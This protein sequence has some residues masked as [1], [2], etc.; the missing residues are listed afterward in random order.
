V[1]ASGGQKKHNFGQI[2]TFG[3]SCTDTVLLMMAKFGLLEETH[4]IHLRAKFRLDRL[5]LSIDV[6]NVFMF[7][8]FL[9][10]FLRFLTFF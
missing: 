10:R 1:S 6:K 3:D 8:L 2:L 5:I 4:G 9:S 7:F